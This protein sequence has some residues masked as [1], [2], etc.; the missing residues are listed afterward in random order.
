MGKDKY[1]NYLTIK[2]EDGILR[3]MAYLW[4]EDDNLKYYQPDIDKILKK[5][6]SFKLVKIIIKEI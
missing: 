3:P 6:K 1:M 5:A 2:D 4:K